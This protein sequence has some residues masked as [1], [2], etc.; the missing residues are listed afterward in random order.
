MVVTIE[1]KRIKIEIHKV[2][3]KMTLD[4]TKCNWCMSHG[5]EY[6]ILLSISKVNKHWYFYVSLIYLK[7]KT[8]LQSRGVVLYIS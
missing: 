6:C 7:F 2:Q 5:G 8:A 4:K 1:L 3:V